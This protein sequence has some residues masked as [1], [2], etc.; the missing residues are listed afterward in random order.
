MGHKKNREHTDTTGMQLVKSRLGISYETTWSK[1]R[2]GMEGDLVAPLVKHLTQ[3]QLMRSISGY[4]IK[5]HIKLHGRYG[6]CLNSFSPSRKEKRRGG[7]AD[8]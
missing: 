8:L 7:V 4:E 2:W 6:A 5:H 3:F 1:K